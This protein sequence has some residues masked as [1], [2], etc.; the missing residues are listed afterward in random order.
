MACTLA[1]PG[2]ALTLYQAVERA[3]CQ[4]PKTREAWAAIKSQTAQVGISKSALMPHVNASVQ[5]AKEHTYTEV[6][7]SPDLSSGGG[8]HFRSDVLALE[9]VLFDFGARYEEMKSAQ[10]LLVAAQQTH[11]A[12]LQQVFLQTAADYYE[13]IAAQAAALSTREMEH[14]AKQSLDTASARV[15]GGVAAVSDQLQAQTAYA[16]AN[17]ARVKAEGMASTSLG[18]LALDMGLSP[19]G[20]FELA[21]TQDGPLNDISFIKSLST[22]LTDARQ[23]H[24][25]ILA[26]QAAV[27]AALA[28]IKSVRANALPMLT[29]NGNISRNTQPVNPGPGMDGL[30]A[31]SKGR[32]VGIVLSVPLFD[33][34]ASAYKIRA[35]DADLEIQKDK[36]QE[37]E[38]QIA[39]EVWRSYQTF[40]VSTENLHNT[41][42]VLQSARQQYAAASER[43]RLGIANVLELISAQTS[44]STALQQR[45]QAMAEWRVSR[46][47]LAASVGILGAWAIR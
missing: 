38:Q 3:L 8:T 17:Y 35:A 33:G 19:D 1:P 41:E 9:W 27:E 31:R 44:L 15:R 30:S 43:Y 18:T 10:Q 22:L 37:A 36:L 21:E 2:S 34:F 24:P 42:T 46:L 25:V 28:R 26:S 40:I 47:E 16:Q 20:H 32:Y 6:P 14:A 29:L 12:T 23:Q 11:A 45:V 39:Q 13:A 4:S 7:N 5:W